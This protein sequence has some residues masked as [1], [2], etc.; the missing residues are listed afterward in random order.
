[1]N[2]GDDPG[3]GGGTDSSFVT[4]SGIMTAKPCTVL[5]F[6]VG[7]KSDCKDFF[8]FLTRFLGCPF[9]P[10]TDSVTEAVSEIISNIEN[11][12]QFVPKDLKATPNID[13]SAY[14][15]KT[16]HKKFL[17]KDGLAIPAEVFRLFQ[18]LAL[19]PDLSALPYYFPDHRDAANIA[20]SSQL[21]QT[22]KSAKIEL[23]ALNLLAAQ[24]HEQ[25]SK[26]DKKVHQ[27]VNSI[28]TS[29]SNNRLV[30]L[31][32]T[33]TLSSASKHSR[34]E[35]PVDLTVTQDFSTVVKNPKQ[36]KRVRKESFSAGTA[37]IAGNSSL[38]F[39]PRKPAAVKITIGKDS[40]NNKQVVNKFVCEHPYFQPYIDGISWDL[41][42]ENPHSQTYRITFPS[43]PLSKD[44]CDLTKWPSGLK[45]TKWVGEIYKIDPSKSLATRT[46]RIGGP[47]L[48][49]TTT[50]EQMKSFIS[51]IAASD[52]SVDQPSL[53]AESSNHSIIVQEMIGKRRNY[54]PDGSKR[55]C[56]FVVKVTTVDSSPLSESIPT[57]FERHPQVHIHNWSGPLPES[58][59]SSN[60]SK[61]APFSF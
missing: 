10:T 58:S 49:P 9:S 1:M 59:A 30:P 51:K 34:D 53:G 12:S 21:Q 46:W 50:V 41:L 35:A 16:Y 36:P 56:N 54:S 60:R 52:G 17:A 4:A 13:D 38:S 57:F 55:F 22:I 48:P 8:T 39:A 19:V 33:R 14:L 11:A 28:T 23:E 3:E 2:T 47:M 61:F 7:L 5:F 37:I 44:I 42:H 18:V 25:V 40:S 15:K 31:S 26:T 32:R 20:K 27:T 45:P 43:W 29:S 24:C 6:A